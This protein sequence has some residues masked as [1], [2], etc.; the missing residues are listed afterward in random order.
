M[1]TIFFRLLQD[2]VRE[3]HLTS[4]NDFTDVGQDDWYCTAVSTL[5]AMGVLEGR[6]AETFE[7]NAP[8][9]R[10]E[11]AAIA[12]RFDDSGLDPAGSFT[13]IAGHWAK[14]EIRQAA[15][16]GW[17]TGYADGSFRPNQSITRAEAV[18][19][20]NR[21]LQRLPETE[22]DLLSGMRTFSDCQSSDWFYLA[23]QEAT[24]SHDYTRR[25]DGYES[26]DELLPDPDWSQYQ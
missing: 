1:A 16:L 21:V 22:E 2:D 5:S 8:I 25:S 13:D 17:I 20:L 11:F 12:V 24:N 9:T 23:I 18:T 3:K 14:D 4:D 15:A 7:P 26:W 19:M 10:A 6:T